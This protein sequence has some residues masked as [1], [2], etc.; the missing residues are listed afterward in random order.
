MAPALS[1]GVALTEAYH[2]VFDHKDRLP[3][4]SRAR[5]LAYETLSKMAELMQALG[6][7]PPSRFDG[8]GRPANKPRPYLVLSEADAVEVFGAL[9]IAAQIYATTGDKVMSGHFQGLYGRLS[10]QT[11]GLDAQGQPERV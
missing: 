6:F 5:Y 4:G 11:K 3:E 1:T 2:T 8:E 9:D 10:N 7:E